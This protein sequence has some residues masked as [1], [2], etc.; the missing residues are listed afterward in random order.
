MIH[1]VYNDFLH[2]DKRL[3]NT[4]AIHRNRYKV[5]KDSFSDPLLTL[6]RK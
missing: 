4:K 2:P 1:D 6:K 5:N 3:D